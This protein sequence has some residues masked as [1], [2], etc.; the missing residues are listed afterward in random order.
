MYNLILP[1]WYL[2]KD[3]T[4]SFIDQDK[5]NPTLKALIEVLRPLVYRIQSI[6]TKEH[7]TFTQI[8]INNYLNLEI[9]TK[10][11]DTIDMIMSEMYLRL[12]V[13]DNQ[14]KLEESF[15]SISSEVYLIQHEL[16]CPLKELE[17]SF[18]Q[19]KEK[20]LKQSTFSSNG[21]TLHYNC[22][23]N[24]YITKDT[25]HPVATLIDG[26]FHFDDDTISEDLIDVFIKKITN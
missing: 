12:D 2:Y 15:Q 6:Q 24:G 11:T 5:S 18:K 1:S 13:S 26:E 8:I 19:A 9:K 4:S 22:F 20:Y 7:Q 10:S 17:E 14:L 3:T 21:F 23:F 25:L 16:Y